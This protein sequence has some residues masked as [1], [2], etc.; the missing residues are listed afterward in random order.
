MLKSVGDVF[1]LH[2]TPENVYMRIDH[3]V[4]GDSL[5]GEFTIG[6]NGTDKVNHLYAGRINMLSVSAK[7]TFADVLKKRYDLEW[8]TVIEQA[9]YKTIEAYRQ[10]E[11]AVTVGDMPERTKNRYRLF[12]FIMEDSMTTLYGLGGSCKSYVAAFLVVMIQTGVGRL[13]FDPIKGNCLI[14]D[15]EACQEDWDERIKAIKLGMDIEA[16]E[17]P[18]YKRCHRI[19]ANDILEIQKLVLEHNIKTVIVDSV[20]MA[21]ELTD[22]YHSSAIQMLRAARSLGCAILLL[23]HESKNKEL[24]GSVYK[25]NEVRS[26]FEVKATQEEGSDIACLSIEHTKINNGPKTK[27]IGLEITFTGDDDH[28]EM[29][30]FKKIDIAD[31]PE[32]SKSLPLKFR[33]ASE[34]KHGA[35]MI[36]LLAEALEQKEDTIRVTLNRN[37]DLFVK[38]TDGSWGLLSKGG[39]Q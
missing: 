14:L 20:G 6:L 5:T 12:P 29:A 39:L 10:G 34:L 22:S 30:I 23:D 28:T 21:S 9:C 18:I 36:S 3:I 38:L 4:E 17:L 1:E 25:L 27:R 32:L 15:W 35:M 19:L 13:G 33:I 24:F 37:K 11:P 2:W 7:K 31:I 26:A 16:P 8:D